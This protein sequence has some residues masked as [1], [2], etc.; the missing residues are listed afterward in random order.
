M[1]ALPPF[2]PGFELLISSRGMSKG[3]EQADQPQVIPKAYLQVGDLQVGGQWKNVTSATAEGEASGFV[4]VSRKFG[5]FAFTVGAAYKFQTGA[6]PGTDSDS[7]EFSGSAS[8]KIGKASLRVSAIYSPDD[9][10]GT[11]RSLYV[12]GGPS[13]DLT[14]T[15]RLSAN[16]GRR[17]RQLAPD[18]TAMNF[19]VTK[20]LFRSF[21]LDLRY[22]QTNR[23]S[24]GDI[25]R[26]RVV[27][28]GRFT[29]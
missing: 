25:Y 5:P 26:R 7:F 27:I 4:N 16:L 23:S 21:S 8:R 15:V 12:E 9:L 3:I 11:R 24:L 1:F 13:F 18:Y 10:G 22:Y 17:S 6:R 29:F 28:A 20:T 14:K 2:D 19:G